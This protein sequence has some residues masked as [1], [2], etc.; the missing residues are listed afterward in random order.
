MPVGL[1]G[2]PGETDRC[3]STPCR[4][5]TP[6]RAA[7][8]SGWRVERVER[9]IARYTRGIF[10]PDTTRRTVAR[11]SRDCVPP[12]ESFDGWPGFYM[13]SATS[14]RSSTRTASR[15][16]C[17]STWAPRERCGSWRDA[18]GFSTMPGSRRSQG[19]GRPRAAARCDAAVLYLERGGFGQAQERLRA[20]VT[21]AVRY[22]GGDPPALT[23]PLAA[24][25]SVGEHAPGLGAASGRAAVGSSPRR[26]SPPMSANHRARGRLDMVARHFAEL[27]LDVDAPYLAPGSAEHYA[28]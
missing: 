28:L 2:P 7:G 27:G 13:A 8:S 14:S 5:P 25:V 24:G 1:I 17:T 3:S 19:G 10:A 20:I 21:V 23:R 12:K 4:E 22:V 6:G 18:R 9:G 16:A 15:S 11:G 26:S